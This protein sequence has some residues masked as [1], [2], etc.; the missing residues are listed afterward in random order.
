MRSKLLPLLKHDPHTRLQ[1]ALGDQV[2][3][4]SPARTYR[5]RANVAHILTTIG[6]VLDQ[7][8]GE[9][10]LVAGEEVITLITASYS[11][12]PMTGVV[13]ETQ[14]KLGHVTTATL[15]L[16]PLPALLN[17]ISGMRIALERSPLP[18]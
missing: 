3:F 5:G 16:R 2:V 15:L 1:E 18:L 12:H 14:D 13:R 7:I 9:R 11:G 8:D 4:H 6:T 17:A 10:E